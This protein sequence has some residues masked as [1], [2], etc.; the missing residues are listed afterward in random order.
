MS[1]N[2]YAPLLIIALLWLGGCA[3]R[4]PESGGV[5][6]TRDVPHEEEMIVKALVYTQEGKPLEAYR[7]YERLY[8]KTHKEEYRLAGMRALLAAKA[9][10]KALQEARALT[11]KEPG[12][13][14]ARK[15]A[16]VSWL[17]LK[18]Q[19]K[20]LSCAKEVV[21]LAPDDFQGVDLLASLYLLSS[22]NESA[23]RVYENYYRRHHDDETVLK[24]ASIRLH[25]MKQPEEALRLL[26][27]HS[28]MIGCGEQVCLFLAELYRKAQNLEGMADVYKRLYETTGRAEY[29]K[30]GAE[31]YAY[32]KAYEKA[33]ALLKNSDADPRLL[34]SL[35]KHTRRFKEAVKLAQR[36]YAQ[37][38]DSL[39]LAEHA[40]LTFE[41]VENKRNKQMI[42][43]VVNELDEAMKRGVDDPLY[44]NYLGYLLIDY[45]M[46][47][48]RGIELVKKAL[49]ADPDSGYYLDSL[50]WGYYK[51]G[52]CDEAYKVM[53][54][55]M[56]SLGHEDKELSAHMKKIEQC[57]SKK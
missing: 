14:E 17:H 54:K 33:E 6:A 42:K 53:K 31:I 41:A 23:Y 9:Y 29:A 30:K 37:T 20:A 12:N 16:C 47:V 24:M 25:R 57:R 44:D 34:L 21:K 2:R 43:Q 40:V 36:L 26:E 49:A 15:I 22:K 13:V 52:H 1:G 35:Y 56:E 32:L 5:P 51:L 50:A 27:S 55:A 7:W 18:K 48:P 4:A 38:D 46:D 10:E 28:K 19:Q 3:G 45:D 39:W 11:A 8:Q